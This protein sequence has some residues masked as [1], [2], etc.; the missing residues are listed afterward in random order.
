MIAAPHRPHPALD[1]RPA[2]RPG[3]AAAL[4]LSASVAAS[5]TACEATT[6]GTPDAGALCAAL[7]SA[8]V[9]CTAADCQTRTGTKT[10]AEVELARDTSADW[11]VLAWATSE[12]AA[13]DENI[14]GSYA[15]STSGA[16]T[17]ARGARRARPALDP[18][19]L[20]TPERVAQLEHER[21]MRSNTRAMPP[22]ETPPLGTGVRAVDL[23]PSGVRRLA[24][25]CTADAPSACGAEALCVI[26]EGMSAGTCASTVMVKFFGL[27][28]QATDVTARVLKVGQRAAI[29]VDQ[30]DEAKLSAADVDALLTRFDTHIAPLDEQLFGSP[31]VSGKDRDQNGVVMLFFTSRVGRLRPN[32]VGY[33]FADDLRATSEVAYS[34]AA[35]VLYLEPPGGSVTLDALS[36]TIGHEYQHLINYTSK[37]LVNRSSREET[38]LDEGLSTFAEDALGYGRDVFANIARY[39]GSVGDVSLTGYGLVNTDPDAADSLERRGFAHLLVRYVFEQKG[40]ATFPASGGG[41]VTDTGGAAAVLR[42]A[43]GAETG[44]DAAMTAQLTPSFHELVRDLML[45]IAIDGTSVSSLTCLTR[46]NFAAPATDG[47][48]Q[49]QRG[50]D[51]RGPIP[52]TTMRY[53]GPATLAAETGVALLPMNGGELRTVRVASGTT[54]LAV[55]GPADATIGLVAIPAPAP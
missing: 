6:T 41:R 39:L 19:L 13:P 36:G 5:L 29:V 26:P 54:R 35:D 8:P 20:P 4:A 10:F 28:P 33:F 51:L 30:A 40:G 55:G 48:T 18:G 14:T 12:V 2:P 24:A 50:V 46:Y 9:R 44:I 27:G 45:T 49:G 25:A 15:L 1:R 37:V 53:N 3:L 34:N 17:A 43:S 16:L 21:W 47:Y 38:W 32:L 7:P 11:W 23:V 42:I 22:A 52:G 31:R